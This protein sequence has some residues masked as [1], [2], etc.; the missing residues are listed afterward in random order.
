M[1]TDPAA[2]LEAY[3][4]TRRL[5]DTLPIARAAVEARAWEHSAIHQ[6]EGWWRGYLA[7]LTDLAWIDGS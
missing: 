5:H 6:D 1:T 2:A 4:I 3:S 7:A